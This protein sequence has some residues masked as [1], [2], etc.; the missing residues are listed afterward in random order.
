M[1]HAQLTMILAEPNTK[2]T[3]SPTLQKKTDCIIGGHFYPPNG[4]N[5]FCTLFVK[6][7][8]FVCKQHHK[9]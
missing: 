4:R 3:G 7:E 2:P 1:D 5:H 9:I 6:D 8:N